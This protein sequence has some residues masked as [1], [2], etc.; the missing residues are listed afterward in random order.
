[1]DRDDSL[2]SEQRRLSDRYRQLRYL[3]AQP[4]IKILVEDCLDLDFSEPRPI[5]MTDDVL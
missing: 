4:L 5:L 2:L 1:M 3:K